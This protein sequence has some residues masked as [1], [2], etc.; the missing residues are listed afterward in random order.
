MSKRSS[1]SAVAERPPAAPQKPFRLAGTGED[2]DLQVLT[3]GGWVSVH[4]TADPHAEANDLVD[5]AAKDQPIPSVV[6]LLGLGLGFMVEALLRRRADVRIVA[7]E[8]VPG[9]YEVCRP[10]H[11]W[12]ELF[13]RGRMVV[14]AEP[15]APLPNPSW[16]PAVV[17]ERPLVIVN[18]I[19]GHFFPEAFQQAKSALK[20]FLYEQR[21][22]AEARRRLAGIYFDHTIDNLPA[23]AGAADV[24]ALDGLAGGQALVLI[25]AGPS[26][27]RLLPELKKHRERAWYVAL[28]TALRPLVNAG[29]VP[30]IVM[31]IDPTLLNG[32]HVFNIPVRERPWLIAEPSIDPRG[33]NAFAG[34]TFVCKIGRAD[35][36]PWLE[37]LGVAPTKLKVWGSVLTASCDLFTRMNAARVIFAGMDLSFTNNQPYCR[38]TSFEEDW[39]LQQRR[40]GLPSLEAVWETRIAE[41]AVE[42]ADTQGKAVRTAPQMVAF[43]NWVRNV[44]A[45]TKG[46]R[47]INAS[48]PATILHGPGIEHRTLTEALKGISGKVSAEEKLRKAASR[49]FTA[50]VPGLIDALEQAAARGEDQSELWSGW[51]EQIPG[52]SPAT[53]RRRLLH[54]ARRIRAEQG[55]KVMAGAI[56]DWVDVP[57][58]A[59]N[60]DAKRPLEWLA[61]EGNVV[62]YAY[63]VEGKTMTLSFRLKK[64][65]LRG[66]P[67]KEIYLKIPAG[68]LPNRSMSNVFWMQSLSHKE[69]GYVTVN[70]GFDRVILRRTTEELFPIE[71]GNFFAFGQLTFEVQ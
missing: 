19:L 21:A 52:F 27:D 38:G 32:R 45:S 65:T 48:G 13:D 29:I 59:A 9:L 67:A 69:I 40:D 62:T 30:D 70:P 36:W 50:A 3:P 2:I 49:P 33:M 51:Q 7:I 17:D 18:P 20:Q 16:P 37:S 31:S 58:D 12:H 22:N 66:V 28:D 54:A 5:R 55:A 61:S 42:D 63:R 68:Y 47:F 10:H 4:D 53:T 23:L 39:Q 6:V 41:V 26:L 35:P 56:S 44:V 14:A 60:F 57:F 11:A 34:R 64:T 1:K 71:H 15:G 25:G 8:L 43:R 46:R 24:S